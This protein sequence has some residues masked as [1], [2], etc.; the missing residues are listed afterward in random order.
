VSEL[1]RAAVVRARLARVAPWLG[2]L[3]AIAIVLAVRAGASTAPLER[4]ARA[5]A[6]PGEPAPTVWT[7]SLILPRGGPYIIGF[8]SA[9]PAA[10]VLA[11]AD[12]PADQPL[13]IAGRGVVTRRVV[14]GVRAAGAV[15]AG[16]PPVAVA[17][18][19]SAPAGARLLWLPPG[20]RG[21]PE[22]VPAAAL[23]SQPPDALADVDVGAVDRARA[24]AI[25]ALAIVLVVLALAGWTLR[26]RL[27]AVARP[28]LIGACAVLAVALAVRLESL[29]DAGQ[30]WD[31]DTYWS[32]GR[33]H[34]HDLLALDLEQSSWIWNYQ[35][36]PVTKYLAG[37]GG[38]WTGGYGPARAVS[39]LVMALACALLVPI[40]AR[41]HRPA[42]GVAAG[43]VA[44]L[45]PHLV[46]HG[47]LVG[48]ES[49]TALAWVV[50]QW[51]SL[52]VW[53]GIGERGREGGSALGPRAAARTETDAEARA[54]AAGE[55]AIRR[56]LVWRLA[57]CG[58]ALGLAVMVRFVNV[59]AAPA[60]GATILLCAPRG[61]RG[62]AIVLGLAVIPVAAALTAIVV[63]P[64]LWSHPLAHLDQAWDRLK[65]KHSGEPFLGAITNDP[66]WW[67]FLPYLAAT[68]PAG[69]LVC[70]VAGKLGWLLAP[71]RRR[72]LAIVLVWALAPLGV[73]LSP[74]RQDGVRYVIPTVVMLSFLAGAGVVVVG[75]LLVRRRPR[76]PGLADVPAAIAIAY[77]AV[78]CL[79]IRPYYLDYY[80]EQVGGPA[81]VARA[82]RFEVAWW[83]EGLAAGIDYVN[84]HAAAGDHVDRRCVEPIHLT[85]FRGDLWEHLDRPP[86]R[87]IVH[88][89]PSWRPCPLPPGATRVFR[90]RAAGAPL[91]DVYRVD[92]AEA[93]TP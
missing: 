5:D 12:L 90:E 40:G 56:R 13:T 73:A 84:R 39:A 6:R 8:Q 23:S 70:A 60:I 47:Q 81:A 62:Q 25:A 11:G 21:E 22:Y 14:L 29:G 75:E 9:G 43:L 68:A 32:A 15:P 57:L 35:H 18:R 88:Y 51:L 28:V 48:H 64:R 74:V 31:E 19:F 89:Q 59:L 79:D 17:V 26:A 86:A 4:L 85:W 55:R 65:G 45:T 53:D 69:L 44:A 87:W 61:R 27:R 37:L 50:A 1:P 42:T 63:W 7:G 92:T 80:G 78:V 82:R 54:D 34:V 38:W 10:L 76:A 2:A 24:D 49:P 33:N 93:G 52:R 72:G 58:V 16:P 20:R 66:P 91:V 71:A 77:L 41:L 46:A 30:T 36:P 67:Y 3:V 83:G